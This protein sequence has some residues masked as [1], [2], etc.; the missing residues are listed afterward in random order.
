[1]KGHDA[2]AS[3]ARKES[4]KGVDRPISI[5]EWRQRLIWLHEELRGAEKLLVEK[6][7]AR[8]AA[9]GRLLLGVGS[10]QAEVEMLE[11]EERKL[12]HQADALRSAVEYGE[13]EIR[14]IETEERQ[15]RLEARRQRR[16]TVAEQIQVEAAA[17]D[18][19]LVELASRLQE[20]RNLLRQYQNEGGVFHR[21]LASCSARAALY[22]GLH[23][24][25]EL[26]FIGGTT[27]HWAPLSRQLAGLPVMLGADLEAAPQAPTTA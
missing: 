10:T 19:L 4:A 3:T 20:V 8:R 24:L 9:A 18:A 5:T 21:S 15:A 27:Q 13:V 6:V 12:E 16:Q 11:S 1:M 14:R 26:G 7:A 23:D 25:L 2:V 22:A 17:A